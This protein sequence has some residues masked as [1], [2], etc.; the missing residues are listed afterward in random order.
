MRRG[1]VVKGLAAYIEQWLLIQDKQGSGDM[2][3]VKKIVSGGQAG[4]DRA[5]LDWAISYDFEHGGWCPLGR[6]AEDGV[7]DPRYQLDEMAHGNYRQRTRQNVLDSDGT[8]ILNLGELDGGSLTTL[9]FA[10]QH[11]K[12]CRVVQ[13]DGDNSNDEVASVFVWINEFQIE[14]LNIA[15]PRE[16]K[17]NG[18]YELSLGFLEKLLRYEPDSCERAP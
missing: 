14:V 17:R 10:E 5:A 2:A 9:R 18:I 8:L 6:L 4:A 16:T 15:G 13:L 12:P 11:R 3:I 1:G 7:I